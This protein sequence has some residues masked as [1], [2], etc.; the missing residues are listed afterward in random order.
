MKFLQLGANGQLGQTFLSE[1][2]LTRRGTVVAASRDGQLPDGSLGAVAHLERPDALAGLLDAERPDIIVNAAA[3]T[4]V[5]KAEQDEAAAR[6]VNADAVAVLGRWAASRD[7]LVVHYST[8]YV[9]D[10]MA[11]SPYTEDAPTAPAGAYGRSKLAGEEALRQSGASHF[12]FRTAWVYSAVGHN[13]LRTML[14]LGAERDEL[15]V[16]ADQR[17]TPTSTGLIVSATLAAIDAWMAAG[18]DARRALQGIYHLTARGETTWHGFAEYL[19]DGAVSNGLLS[20]LPRVTP[21]RTEEFPTP[22]R[23]PAYS[24]LDTRRFAE[25]FHFD[26]PSWQTG[27]DNVLTTLSE[28]AD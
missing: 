9:F 4:A 14:R 26:I 16:V 17:G 15:R 25:T 22:A 2:G 23:R 18:P 19:L 1:R 24:V 20:R 12:I 13:F 8:D 5:D 7:V 6:R 10:G 21:I 27:V 28:H 3:Y 11:A